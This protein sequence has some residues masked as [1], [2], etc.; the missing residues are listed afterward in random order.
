MFAPPCHRRAVGASAVFQQPADRAV[1]WWWISNLSP[2]TPRL[3]PRVIWDRFQLR[4][5]DESD[6]SRPRTTALEA[7][8][9]PFTFLTGTL[10][11]CT[12]YH[13]FRCCNAVEWA[14]SRHVTAAVTAEAESRRA[15]PD[16]RELNVKKEKAHSE[17][18]LSSRGGLERDQRLVWKIRCCCPKYPV[19]LYPVARQ[20]KR[21]SPRRFAFKILSKYAGTNSTKGCSNPSWHLCGALCPGYLIPAVPFELQL[22]IWPRASF[23]N[24]ECP[25][26]ADNEQSDV[27]KKKEL[28]S[29]GHDQRGAI[30]AQSHSLLLFI[31]W[32]HTLAIP[33]LP[34]CHYSW[35]SETLFPPRPCSSISVLS[36][37]GDWKSPPVSR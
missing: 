36:Q 30:M 28:L 32:Q 8:S 12:L 1:A 34:L 17:T 35:F 4:P 13:S 19:L 9:C 26:S 22:S 21:K 33:R 10:L 18:M 29:R 5:A 31:K 20:F 11:N 14:F 27:K 7:C 15:L 23:P 25:F 37:F 16:Y 3:S 6:F 24:S 2:N